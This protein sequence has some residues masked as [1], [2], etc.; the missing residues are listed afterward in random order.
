MDSDK[1]VETGMIGNEGLIGILVVLNA[2]TTPDE[3]IYQL[4]V[5]DLVVPVA[6]FRAALEQ[7]SGLRSLFGRYI[8][9]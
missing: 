7:P 5:D 6:D 1:S 8:Q 4:A 9:C 2:R 3:I